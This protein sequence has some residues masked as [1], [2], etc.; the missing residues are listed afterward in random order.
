MYI[1][2]R[3]K[4]SKYL[5]VLLNKLKQEKISEWKFRVSIENFDRVPIEFRVFLNKKITQK[6]LK[7]P[8]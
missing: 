4:I 6:I 3:K 7:Y 8:V 5:I 2:N 1:F